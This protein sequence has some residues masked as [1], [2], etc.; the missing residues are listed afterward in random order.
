[1]MKNTLL[2]ILLFLIVST[3]Q[4]QH[5]PVVIP[6]W[7]NGAPGFEEK[8]NEA[9]EAKEYWVKNVHNPSITVFKPEKPNG[10]AVLIFPGGGHRLLVFD[11]EGTKTARFLNTLG[12]TGIVLKYRLFREKDSPYTIQHPKE[13]AVRAMRLIRAHAA[14]WNLDEDRIGIMGFSAGGEVVNMI[15]FEDFPGDLYSTDAVELKKA[16]ANFHIQIYPGPL[17]IPGEVSSKAVPAFLLGS[18]N[19]KCCAEPIVQLLIAYRKAGA[20]VEVH[21][22]AKGDH[23]FNMGDRSEYKSISHWPARLAEWLEDNKFFKD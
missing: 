4:S 19:D 5:P 23:G 2:S 18:N 22:Y 15:A 17:G 1:M 8:K 20:P 13:D 7:E 12:V 6:L 16:N 10:S 3:V 14:E 9:E 11:E 21:F